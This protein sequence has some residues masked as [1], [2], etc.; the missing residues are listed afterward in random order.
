VATTAASRLE[1]EPA[2]PNQVGALHEE[3]RRLGLAGPRHREL[4]HAIGAGLLGLTEVGGWRDLTKGQAGLLLR[5]LQDFASAD[6]AIAAAGLRTPRQAAS[7]KA[8]T[9]LLARLLTRYI[10][11][12]LAAR[13]R[14]EAT[15]DA[16]PAAPVQADSA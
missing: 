12:E 2:T 13:I 6:E 7:T 1:T 10:A 11:A 5:S 3:Y 4:R 15:R 8:R 14:Q 16:I 9:R